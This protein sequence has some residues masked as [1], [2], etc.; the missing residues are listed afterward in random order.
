M[1]LAWG[2]ALLS[3]YHAVFIPAGMLL[4]FLVHRPHA[5]LAGPAGSVPGDGDRTLIFSPVIVWNASHGWVSF[6]FQGGRAVGGWTPRPD[7]LLMAILAQAGYLFPWI[8]I[9]LIVILVRKLRGWSRIASDHERLWLCLAVVPV[10]V[11]T[12]VACFRPVLPHWGLIGLVSLFPIL[13][14]R[15]GGSTRKSPGD[16][17]QTS[18]CGRGLCPWPC[19]PWRSPSTGMAGFSAERDGRLGTGRRSHRSHARP[20]RLGPGGG[21]DRAARIDRRSRQ[22][23]VH[24]ATGI[25]VPSSPTHSTRSVRFCAT[26]PTIRA[27][28]PSGASP[29]NGS[30]AMGSWWWSA[31]R[32]RRSAITGA[33]FTHVE[34]VSD[35]WVERH[36]KPVRRITLYR[37]D[38]QRFAYPFGL[39]RAEM[40]ARHEWDRDVTRDRLSR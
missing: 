30:V 9:P 27:A 23:R 11:F 15:L 6:L 33:W 36:G 40:L 2:G 39:D 25:R 19:W 24:A 22:F 8:W 34:R 21:S 14:H 31:S 38:Q 37:C 4:Y 12:A 3:K 1:G 5:A 10:G 13:G 20:L 18:L 7:Y 29:R 32:T 17:S 35:F 28:L 16:N 26:T